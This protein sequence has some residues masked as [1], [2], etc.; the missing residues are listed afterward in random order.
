MLTQYATVYKYIHK[1]MNVHNNK[2]N[3]AFLTVLL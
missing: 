2:S 3:W 1:S